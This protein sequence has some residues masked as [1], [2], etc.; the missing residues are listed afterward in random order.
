MKQD[1]FKMDRREVA[2]F[3]EETKKKLGKDLTIIAHNFTADDLM[4][5]ADVVGDSAKIVDSILKSKS[6]Y[7]L[8]T[9]AKFFTEAACILVP[10]RNIIQANLKADCPL[11]YSID[12]N[13]TRK[14]FSEIQRKSDREIVPMAYFTASYQLKSFCGENNGTTS[15]ASNSTKLIDY[16]LKKNKSIFFTP[17]NNIAF[18]AIKTLKISDDD[19]FVLDEK[20][21]LDSIPG[22]KKLYV[23]DVGCYV[24][25]NFTV[26]DIRRV[27]EKYKDDNIKVIA[28]LECLPEVIAESDYAEFTDGMGEI[29]RKSAPG[30]CWGIATTNNY[31][32]RMAKRYTDRKIVAVRPDLLCKDM[33]VTDL[34]HVAESLQSIID[35]KNGTGE[36]KYK[37]EVPERYRIYAKKA[38][39]TMFKINK[40]LNVVDEVVNF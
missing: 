11:T 20:T 23:W 6:E 36:L 38:I 1:F 5:Y 22:N 30:T 29:I 37:M 12:E 25:S 32:V 39:E 13:D 14:A 26:E 31:A 15:T 24:H 3:I 35:Y 16:Y 8:F 21:P 17:M 28:H 9:A 34:P 10:N 2:K 7:L 33:V 19:V 27:K 4:P 18:N 40:E